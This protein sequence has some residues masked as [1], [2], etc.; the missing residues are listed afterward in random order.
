MKDF[1]YFEDSYTYGYKFVHGYVIKCKED[2]LKGI[3]NFVFKNLYCGKIAESLYKIY[4]FRFEKRQEV[5]R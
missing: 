1:K 5:E 3:R 2:N 4:E